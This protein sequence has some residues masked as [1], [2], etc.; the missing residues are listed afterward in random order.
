MCIQT[1]SAK[2]KRNGRHSRERFL[3]VALSRFY[4]AV[5]RALM[6]EKVDLVPIVCITR[7]II[8]RKNRK[9]SR[10]QLEDFSVDYLLPVQIGNHW[11]GIVYRN[12]VCHMSLMD[13][14]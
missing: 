10:N 14:C 1:G 8:P 12:N 7:A 5:C 9:Y 6:D 11:V 2:K 3:E 13:A 4:D